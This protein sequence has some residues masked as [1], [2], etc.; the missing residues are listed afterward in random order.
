MYPLVHHIDQTF[1][2]RIAKVAL[3]WQAEMN[4]LLGQWVC[5]LVGVDTR[6]EAGYDLR[7]ASN[8]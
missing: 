5:Y 2:V 1:C 4:V 8:L 3:V 7:Y 6:R